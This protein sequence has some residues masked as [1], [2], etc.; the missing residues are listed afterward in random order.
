MGNF[1]DLTCSCGEFIVKSVD[2]KTKVRSRILVFEEGTAFAK[3]RGC[4]DMHEVPIQMHYVDENKHTNIS[5][6]HKKRIY[7]RNNLT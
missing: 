5:K 4:G 2:G 1:E 7:I 6:S 3:C